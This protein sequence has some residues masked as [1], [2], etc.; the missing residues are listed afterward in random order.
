MRSLSDQHWDMNGKRAYAMRTLPIRS[1]SLSSRILTN[2]SPSMF[3]WDEL[4]F[5]TLSQLKADELCRYLY[6]MR[7]CQSIWSMRS[8]SVQ[9]ASCSRNDIDWWVHSSVARL[10]RGVSF[11]MVPWFSIRKHHLRCDS[12]FRTPSTVESLY[13]ANKLTNPLPR[14]FEGKHGKLVDELELRCNTNR[15]CSYI[16]SFIVL[17]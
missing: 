7:L 10:R 2:S 17:F 15:A 1:L 9:F 16:D 5:Q 13:C 8:S 4:H 14:W 11:D 3:L 12:R 6:R